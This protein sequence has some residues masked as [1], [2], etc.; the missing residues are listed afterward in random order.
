[1]KARSSEM[2]DAMNTVADEM[3]EAEKLQKEAD[4]KEHGEFYHQRYLQD[5]QKKIEKAQKRLEEIKGIHD[6]CFLLFHTF[7]F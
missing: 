4:E 1:M 2:R 6:V 5:I 7:S 3:K